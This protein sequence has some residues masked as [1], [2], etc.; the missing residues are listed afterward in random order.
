M[1]ID[2]ARRKII[3]KTERIL[4]AI[5]SRPSN[6]DK[7]KVDLTSIAKTLSERRDKI[8]SADEGGK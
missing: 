8:L 6:K 2:K 4:E 1:T 5:D 3:A 7:E